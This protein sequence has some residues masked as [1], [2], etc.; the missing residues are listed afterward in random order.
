[1]FLKQKKRT[2]SP[3]EIAA[4]ILNLNWLWMHTIVELINQSESQMRKI[5]ARVTGPESTPKFNS[6]TFF[7]TVGH[8]WKEKKTIKENLFFSHNYSIWN[9]HSEVTIPSSEEWTRS[10]RDWRNATK[11]TNAFASGQP[12]PNESRQSKYLFYT[13]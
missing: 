2:Y 11:N 8:F 13:A 5:T 10:S 3:S 9:N 4:L 7:N 6:M 1:M 12:N